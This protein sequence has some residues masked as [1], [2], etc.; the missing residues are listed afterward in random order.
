MKNSSKS[1]ILPCVIFAV[2]S[3]I[4]GSCLILT[5]DDFFWHHMES[6]TEN[7]GRSSHN[8]RYFTNIITYTM[9]N[10]SALRV[11][12]YFIVML[13]MFFAVVKLLKTDANRSLITNLFAV[14]GLL[15]IPSQIYCYTFNWISGFTN[16]VLGTVM[17]L[18]YIVWCL[19]LLKGE[20]LKISHF[21][22]V[23]TLLLGFLGALCVENLTI[24]N[25]LFAIFILIFSALTYKKVHLSN[26]FYLVGASIGAF[27][28]FTNVNYND[29]LVEESDQ[30]GNRFAE[31]SLP[32][33]FM[34]V[35]MDIIPR[36]S[37]M[38]FIPNL[39]IGLAILFLYA[40][41]FHSSE[42]K[43]PK[44][45]NLFAGVICA[46]CAYSVFT[47][48]MSDLIPVT[49]TYRIRAL[50]T[51]FV[52]LYIVA[53]IY[54]AYILSDR[55]TFVRVTLYIVATVIVTAPFAVVNPV[56]YRC[57]FSDYVFWF[58]AAGE[59]FI[60][61]VKELDTTSMMCVKFL[62]VAGAS[63]MVI[64]LSGINITNK[65]TDVVRQDYFRQQVESDAPVLEYIELP[66]TK[67]AGN[68]ITDLANINAPDMDD[69]YII[70]YFDYMGIDHEAVDFS[71]ISFI[72]LMDYF[73]IS[74]T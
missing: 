39:V 64:F 71:K 22:A 19:P 69:K 13:L 15:S 51:A 55:F 50:E 41:K 25:I 34:K 38:F 9:C 74:E 17:T 7:F 59:F 52:F 4:Q 26:I 45:A 48:F 31:F 46:Y 56:T 73:T 24:L 27:F 37:K 57:F 28:M 65:Y 67:Y 62:T 6:F 12:I 1:F 8:G 10:Y 32:D 63:V 72:S 47:C 40:K 35:Y 58:L 11:I 54:M 3:L 68:F 23:F 44:Y 43:P 5:G 49:P 29:V 33:I 61:L 20:E 16:Y 60:L 66:Y 14:I 30:I 36:Y 42:N 21:S 70:Y 18:L 53:I 2:F